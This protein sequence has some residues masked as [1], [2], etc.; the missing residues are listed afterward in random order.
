VVSDVLRRADGS[1]AEKTRDWYAPDNH[2]HVDSREG[3]WEAGV[4]G[5]VADAFRSARSGR[6]VRHIGGRR[7]CPRGGNQ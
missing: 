4:D 5:A 6:S 7:A 2:G 1:A 3:Y